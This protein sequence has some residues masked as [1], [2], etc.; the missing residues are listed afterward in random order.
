MLHR[1]HSAAGTTCTC[2]HSGGFRCFS[3]N[4]AVLQRSATRPRPIPLPQR[5]SLSFSGRRARIGLPAR[6][7]EDKPAMHVIGSAAL[8]SWQ[9]QSR[10]LQ[11]GPWIASHLHGLRSTYTLRLFH[12][13]QKNQRFTPVG[14]HAKCVVRRPDRNL[15]TSH[16]RVYGGNPKDTH[17]LER[18][19]IAVRQT[20]ATRKTRRPMRSVDLGARKDAARHQANSAKMAPGSAA[21][22]GRNRLAENGSSK[23]SPW[24][25]STEDVSLAFG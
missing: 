16:S 25:Q 2:G 9:G 22:P 21:D 17:T 6:Q 19:T 8:P 12:V 14:L 10:T 3:V 13:Q 18:T 20:F 7:P 24:K 1:T 5:S 11:H 4:R 15:P 23:L